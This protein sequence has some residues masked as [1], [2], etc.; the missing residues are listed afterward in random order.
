[1]DELIPSARILINKIKIVRKKEGIFPEEYMS[2][3]QIKSNSSVKGTDAAIGL[4][5]ETHAVSSSR[6]ILILVLALAVLAGTF[7]AGYAVPANSMGLAAGDIC[8]CVSTDACPHQQSPAQAG[9]T[10]MPAS[11]GCRCS[12]SAAP[13]S[14]ETPVVLPQIL[15]HIAVDG[16]AATLPVLANLPEEPR[17][18]WP[19]AN[20]Q[21]TYSFLYASSFSGRAPPVSAPIICHS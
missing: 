21:S 11:S 3:Y 1:L 7:A 6:Y 14:K 2:L 15:R 19:V 16:L 5:L 10:N 13:N 17:H 8:K 20:E 12:I 4:I 18:W 9:C